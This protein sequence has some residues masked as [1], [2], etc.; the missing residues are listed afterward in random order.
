VLAAALLVGLVL[1]PPLVAQA[2]RRR[3]DRRTGSSGRP[4]AFQ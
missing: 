1:T 2:S 4:G 3:R